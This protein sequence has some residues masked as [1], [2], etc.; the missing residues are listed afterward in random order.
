[1][2]EQLTTVD[3]QLEKIVL[4]MANIVSILEADSN[5]AKS[6]SLTKSVDEPIE[7]V[8]DEPTEELKKSVGDDDAEH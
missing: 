1:M 4:A 7:E 2:D 5:N 6:V 3:A 8:K